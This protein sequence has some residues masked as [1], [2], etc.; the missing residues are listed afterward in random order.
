MIV[1][2]KRNRELDRWSS[3]A[4]SYHIVI[5]GL[6][7]PWERRIVI[8]DCKAPSA[9]HLYDRQLKGIRRRS[10]SSRLSPGRAPGIRDP[11]SGVCTADFFFRRRIPPPPRGY[12]MASFTHSTCSA[13]LDKA[14]AEVESFCLPAQYKGSIECNGHQSPGRDK[15]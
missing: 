12:G 14:G 2:S 3:G 5:F 10:P 13:S 8:T 6:V 15:G 1:T 9:A 4:T 7:P 11:L